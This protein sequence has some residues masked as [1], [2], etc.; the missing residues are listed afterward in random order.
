MGIRAQ[1]D[2]IQQYRNAYFLA[3]SVAFGSVFFGYDI[4][5]IGG[6]LAL[7]SFQRYFGLDTLAP[8]EKA[9]VSGNIVAILQVG[10]LLGALGISPFSAR[11]GR[12]PCL[13]ASGVVF[14]AGSALQVVS[15]LGP[16]KDHALL[17]LYVGRFIG[18]LGVG[19]VTA[20]VPAYLSESTPPTIRGRCT[21]LIQLA[22]NIGIALSFWVNYFASKNMAPTDRQWRLPFMMQIIPGILFLL[23]TPM[24]PESPRY[25]IEKEQYTRAANTLAYLNNCAPDD[26]TVLDT[27]QDVKADFAGKR[28]LSFREQAKAVV[29]SR[30]VFVRCAIPPLVMTFQQFTG[31]N[32]INYW[33]PALFARLGIGDTTAELFATG[34]YGIVKVISVATVLALAVE[35]FGRRKSLI[36]GGIGQSFMML[37]M[38][39]YGALHPPSDSPTTSSPSVF[40]Y[41]SI[42]A[43]YFYAV[44]Y[45]VG[46]G[47]MPWIVAGEVAPN[48]LR[49]AVMSASVG[50]SWLFSMTISKIT[51]LLLNSWG[52]GT[53]LLFSACCAGMALWTWMFLPETAGLGLEEIGR[54]FET[55]SAG[56]GRW[57]VHEA[58]ADPTQHLTMHDVLVFG[59]GSIG[60]IYA[61]ILQTG[62]HA[63]VSVVARSNAATMKTKGM[64]L[65]SEKFGN[66]TGVKFDAVYTNCEEAASSGRVFAY[67][68]CTNKAI[69]DAKPS[70]AEMI[71]PVISE[72]TT[73]FLIQ[74]GFGE[75]DGLYAAFPSTTVLTSAGW[76][77]ARFEEDGSVHMLLPTDHLMVG[78]DRT[79]NLKIPRERQ[80]KDLD[81]LVDLLVKSNAKITVDDDVASQRW[82]KLVW[83]ATWNTLTALTLIRTSDFIHTSSEAV[84]VAQALFQETIA[85]GRAKGLNIPEDTLDVVMHRYRTLPGSMSSMLMDAVAK[86]PMEVE[87]LV[88]YPVREAE[89][90]GVPVPTLKTIY[91][92][93]KGVAWRNANPEAARLDI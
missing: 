4:G 14:V 36:V 6:V 76:T 7:D 42:S 43:I 53:F 64:S 49:T 68:I 56:F 91:A 82:I 8:K 21:G 12:K 85:V 67:V 65:R 30:S 24:Q 73:I 34:V 58:E 45:N 47:P 31:T 84:P 29:E 71:R 54:L 52:Y 20:L 15:G 86:K 41:L 69:L 28:R 23:F 27:I 57:R 17:V 38:G 16:T 26:D 22:N 90:L 77:V 9:S 70:L 37:W 55:R 75:E 35:T 72:E 33:S 13:L 62:G 11:Y 50:C 32:A 80:Q 81:G 89:R 61:F 92:L 46:W 5:L 51:P 93:L 25:L 39:V 83:N 3:L 78:V 10:C 44:F 19:M 79:Q 60:S 74:N 88:G 59:L 1:L 18:G 66:H 40:G 87:C 48:H 2:E 63:R